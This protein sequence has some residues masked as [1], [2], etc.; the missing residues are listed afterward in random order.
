MV[1]MSSKLRYM[2]PI[3]EYIPVAAESEPTIRLE[4]TILHHDGYVDWGGERDVTNI[5]T[6][7]ER[8]GEPFPGHCEPLLQFGKIPL[9]RSK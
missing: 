8:I 6:D 3:H 5:Q 9:V 4:R 1:R 2:S 7:K